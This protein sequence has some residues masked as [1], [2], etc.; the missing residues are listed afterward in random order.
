M[1]NLENQA[2]NDA[3]ANKNMM[4]DP[5]WSAEERKKYQAAYTNAKNKIDGK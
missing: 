5:N 4:D 1:S 3:N 2:V